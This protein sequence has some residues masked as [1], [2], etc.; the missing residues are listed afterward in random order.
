MDSQLNFFDREFTVKNDMQY[1]IVKNML[2][3]AFM[4]PYKMDNINMNSNKV[5]FLGMTPVDI[6]STIQTRINSLQSSI[7]QVFYENNNYG[8]YVS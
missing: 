1:L 3:V 4:F 8:I 7:D 5:N 6:T 2:K